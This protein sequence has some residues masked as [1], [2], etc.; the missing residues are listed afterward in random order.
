MNTNSRPSLAGSVAAGAST[1]PFEQIPLSERLDRWVEAGAA[2]ENR[3]RARQLIDDWVT[4]NV[5]PGAIGSVNAS[6]D[7][8]NMGLTEMPPLPDVRYLN[9]YGN[10]L[11]TLPPLTA[12]PTNLARIWL[13]N[14]PTLAN[15][16]SAYFESHRETPLV[17]NLGKKEYATFQEQIQYLTSE[18]VQ[19]R[20]VELASTSR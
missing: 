5:G 13:R 17:I 14:N 1:G 10:Q 19:F 4:A 6:L 9:L 2:G 15:I 3:A 8:S 20:E 7:L 16:P 12:L 18:N 11:T